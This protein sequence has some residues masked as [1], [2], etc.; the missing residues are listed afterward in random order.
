LSKPIRAVFRWQ[1][2][3]TVLAMLVGGFAAGTHGALSAMLGGL[4][5]L[6]PGL[7]AGWVATRG[8][9]RSAGAT[10]VA[11]LTAEAVKIGLIVLLLWLVLANYEAVVVLAFIGT[12]LVTAL[13]FSM[14]FFVR[15]Y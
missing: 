15:D 14:A 9:V 5:A 1:V 13:I 7:V 12:F 4:V 10:V 3:A 11:A 2:W 8:N 6:L